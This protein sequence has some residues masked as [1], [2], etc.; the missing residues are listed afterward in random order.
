MTSK[1]LK[2]IS[3]LRKVS[4][5]TVDELILSIVSGELLSPGLSIFR[6]PG[7]GLLFLHGMLLCLLWRNDQLIKC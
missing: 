3:Q 6:D 2:G 7:Q 4:V 5:A 1:I